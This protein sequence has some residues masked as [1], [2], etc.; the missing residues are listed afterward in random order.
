MEKSLALLKEK[1]ILR[2]FRGLVILL[3]A[4]L[5]AFGLWASLQAQA[6]PSAT[7]YSVNSTLDEPDATVGDGQCISTPSGKC[8]LRAAL[9]QANVV[10]VDTTISLPAG[11]Y[12]LTIP[13]IGADGPETGDLNLTSPTS[14]NPTISIVGAGAASTIIDG[15]LNDRVFEIGTNR[16]ARISGVTIQNGYR[17][18]A[19]SGIGGGISTFG[20]LTLTHST[21][22]H[23]LADRT[24][25]GIY[26]GGGNLTVLNSTVSQNQAGTLGGGLENDAVLLVRDSTIVGNSA[27]RGG[28]VYNYTTLFIVNSTISQNSVTDDG[29]GIANYHGIANVYNTSI[30]FN[31][32]DSD[33]DVNGGSGGGAF[34]LD[35]N[36]TTFNLRNTLVAGNTI[37]N[38]PVND[39]CSGTLNS[40]G[41]NLFF[42]VSGCTVNI[43]TGTWG[44]LNSLALLGPLRNNGGPTWTHALLQGSNA[45][46][47]GDPGQGC[48]DYISSSI[49]TDQRGAARA[50]DG[51]HDGVV[52]CDIGA[53]EYQPPL[54]LP[55][56]R[57]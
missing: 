3:T 48:V 19:N 33:A 25:G 34:N 14:G 6:A 5:V 38:Q 1:H 4:W 37:H 45:I 47:G 52:R 22:T 20:S 57:R 8:T 27:E 24:G 55:L 40:Y 13:P 56:I 12:T 42:D 9:M 15:N 49:T 10:N 46:D 18:E 53:F 30:L 28:G 23:N 36:G 7:T 21:L 16:H 43:S 41:R 17:P 44:M 35:G 50:V 26:N 29:G 11:V 31:D 2:K 51:N 32:A 54:Y 39:D